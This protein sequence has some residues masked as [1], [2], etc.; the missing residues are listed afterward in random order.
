MASPKFTIIGSCF[1]N[2]RGNFIVAVRARSVDHV[3]QVSLRKRADRG[4]LD[5]PA[6]IRYHGE[7]TATEGAPVVIATSQADVQARVPGSCTAIAHLRFI[8]RFPVIT[9][10]NFIFFLTVS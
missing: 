1:D 5:A 10:D 9:S 7:A 6:H 8:S 3:A 2:R 4:T